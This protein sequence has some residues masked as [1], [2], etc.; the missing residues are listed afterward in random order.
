MNY[1]KYKPGS[2]SEG[3]IWM[4]KKIQL[5]CQTALQSQ[6]TWQRPFKWNTQPMRGVQKEIK[7]F[8]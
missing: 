5:G 6:I 1:L 8:K 2:H 7:L 3:N 4:M